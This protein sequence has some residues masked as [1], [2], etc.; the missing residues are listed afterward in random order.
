M[1]E[2]LKPFWEVWT[3]PPEHWHPLLIHFPIV[4]LI[5]EAVLLGLFRLTGKP[6]YE[7]W[8]FVFLHWGFWAIMVAAVAGFH[9]VGLDLGVGN[10]IWLGL[11][12]RWHNVFRFQSAI[13][14]HAWLALG[15]LVITLTRL[16]WRK[17]GGAVAIRGVRGCGYA[18]LTFVSLWLLTAA[19]YVGGRVVYK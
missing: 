9:D 2:L 5:L 17:L 15:L 11:Q 1:S 3:A 19:A 8:S 6:D 16:L 13:T 12:D 10:R 7:R 4:F 14:V 18:G